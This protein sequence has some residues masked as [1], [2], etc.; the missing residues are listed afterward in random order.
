MAYSSYHAYFYIIDILD[1]SW[2]IGN[3][4][5][6]LY[7]LHILSYW[8]YY[9]YND[10]LEICCVNYICCICCICN[11]LSDPVFHTRPRLWTI[12]WWGWCSIASRSSS[13]KSWCAR[14]H[15]L[16]CFASFTSCSAPIRI[17]FFYTPLRR[18]YNQFIIC[19]SRNRCT[20]TAWTH[21]CLQWTGWRGCKVLYSWYLNMYFMSKLWT[22]ISFLDERF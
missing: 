22:K 4:M 15:A 17:F 8:T 16:A 21:Y 12:K 3:I 10:I 5:Y 2:H 9:S 7:I 13:T 18:R 20:L 1:I 14:R 6:I 11:I 19:H